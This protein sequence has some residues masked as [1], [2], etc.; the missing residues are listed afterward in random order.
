[1]RLKTSFIL[2]TSNEIIGG[3]DVHDQLI[4][5][6]IFLDH[7]CY[8]WLSESLLVNQFYETWKMVVKPYI[9]SLFTLNLSYRWQVNSFLC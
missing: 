5:E 1:M 8:I 6:G 9:L 3:G 2:G 7:K 4:L